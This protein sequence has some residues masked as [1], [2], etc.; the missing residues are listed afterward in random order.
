MVVLFLFLVLIALI[1]NFEDNSYLSNITNSAILLEGICTMIIGWL[2]IRN[3]IGK[4]NDKYIQ[5]KF[6][7]CFLLCFL[8]L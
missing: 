8:F 3:T 1:L 6:L 2:L 7:K 4:A 5:N